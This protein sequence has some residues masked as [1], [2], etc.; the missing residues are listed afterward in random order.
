M[1]TFFQK[2]HLIE[3]TEAFIH[4]NFFEIY[5]KILQKIPQSLGDQKMKYQWQNVGNCVWVMGTQGFIT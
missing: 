3:I 2:T 4:E 5:V 1:C